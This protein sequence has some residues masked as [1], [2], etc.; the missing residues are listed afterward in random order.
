MHTVL[1]FLLQAHLLSRLCCGLG[2]FNSKQA[3]ESALEAVWRGLNPSGMEPTLCHNVAFFN[4]CARLK[5]Y[6]PALTAAQDL[7]VPACG[8]SRI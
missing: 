5:L 7:K 3:T 1:P 8:D 4:A 2:T 6:R